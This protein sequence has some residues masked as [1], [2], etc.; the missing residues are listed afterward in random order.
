[1]KELTGGRGA[2]VVIEVTDAAFQNMRYPQFVT[3]L[4][5]ISFSVEIHDA[6][7]TNDFEIGDLR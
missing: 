1:M 4:P 7:P 6:R 3:D 5:E 2:D